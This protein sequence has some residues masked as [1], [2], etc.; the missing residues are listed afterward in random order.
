[1]TLYINIE[2]AK[3]KGAIDILKAF[4]KVCID[5]QDINLK[6]FIGPYEGDKN[7]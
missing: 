3:D 1:M 5:N 6:L 2:R 4:E 7:I